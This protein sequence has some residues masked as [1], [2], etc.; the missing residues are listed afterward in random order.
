VLCVHSITTRVSAFF[1]F[2]L[3]SKDG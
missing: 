3:R 2:N 1:N